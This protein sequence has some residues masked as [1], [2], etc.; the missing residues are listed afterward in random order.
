MI[1]FENGYE[2]NM[3]SPKKSTIEKPSDA[4]TMIAIHLE[5]SNKHFA[6]N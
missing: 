2:L 5:R 3:S 4:K 1:V 6:S